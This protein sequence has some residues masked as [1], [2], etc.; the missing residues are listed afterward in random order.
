MEAIAAARHVRPLDVATLACGVP[1]KEAQRMAVTVPA[2]VMG[3][4]RPARLEGRHAADLVLL[5]DVPAV[6]DWRPPFG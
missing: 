3:L 4:D 2:R 1:P 5:D 6:V